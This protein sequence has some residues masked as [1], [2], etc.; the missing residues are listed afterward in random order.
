MNEEDRQPEAVDRMLRR[1]GGDELA[2]RFSVDAAAAPRRR[3]ARRRGWLLPLCLSSVAATAILAAGW[4]LIVSS[5]S[6]E[7]S[8]AHAAALRTEITALEQRSGDLTTRL[9]H[10][11]SELI[12]AQ[13]GL[14]AATRRNAARMSVLQEKFTAQKTAVASATDRIKEL[15]RTAATRTGLL[16]QA[17]T[18]L[19]RTR[20]LLARGKQHRATT[21]TTI[22][23]LRAQV[24][25][26]AA[27]A[28]RLRQRNQQL[29]ATGDSTRNQLRTLAVSHARLTA[30]M[31]ALRPPARPDAFPAAVQRTRW[32]VRPR[33]RKRGGGRIVRAHIRFVQDVMPVVLRFPETLLS[34]VSQDN[35]SR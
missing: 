18:E 17:R 12:A 20:G 16:R 25:T 28:D 2:R 13:E 1:W 35:G 34:A 9:K 7:E 10:A 3:P 11:D 14:A 27:E 32:P 8:D 5:R 15:E 22:Q 24:T 23:E 21:E 19:E 30:K 26:R 31:V 4:L 6:R 33:R 29:Q